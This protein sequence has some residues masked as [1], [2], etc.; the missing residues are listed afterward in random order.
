MSNLINDY[1]LNSQ[2]SMAAYAVGL[3]ASMTSEQYKGA[4]KDTDFSDAQADA[5]IARYDIIDQQ[6]STLEGFSGTVFLDTQTGEYVLSLRG[7]EFETEFLED[8]ARA[9]FGDIGGNGIAVSQAIDMYN[10]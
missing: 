8:V 1:F 10:Y 4:L 2:L 6:P 9:D 7:T 3:N 5:F